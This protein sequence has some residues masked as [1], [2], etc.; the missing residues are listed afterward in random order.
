M[1]TA[2]RGVPDRDRGASEQLR[3]G[4]EPDRSGV[5]IRLVG[6]VDLSTV[7]ELDRM[8]DQLARSGH[9]RLLIDLTG[10]EFMDSSGL[11]SILRA[12]HAADRNGHR[13]SVCCGSSQVQR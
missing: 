10:V 7:P 2:D 8:L 6:E 1:Q 4:L 12:L 13:L 9:S 11:A 5:R 3:I